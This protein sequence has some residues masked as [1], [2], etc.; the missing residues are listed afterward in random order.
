M[1]L[2]EHIKVFVEP[3]PTL[4]KDSPSPAVDQEKIQRYD[5]SATA[6]ETHAPGNYKHNE[7]VFDLGL[8]CS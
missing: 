6:P 5:G 2:A 8:P 4:T 7:C 1:E 3:Q